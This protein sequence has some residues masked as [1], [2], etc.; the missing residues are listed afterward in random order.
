M[1]LSILLWLGLI[2]LQEPALAADIPYVFDESSYDEALQAFDQSIQTNPKIAESWS[3]KGIALRVTHQYRE[4]IKFF[5][6]VTAP[7]PSF[8]AA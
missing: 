5:D 1:K 3:Y 4:A 8:I 6:E 2:F 7:E